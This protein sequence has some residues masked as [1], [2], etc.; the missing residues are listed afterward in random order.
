[1]ADLETDRPDEGEGYV[2]SYLRGLIA[3]ALMLAAAVAV[4]PAAQAHSKCAS[5]PGGGHA[6]MRD[7]TDAGTG[8]HE[9]VDI[10]DSQA[11]GNYV[12]VRAQTIWLGALLAYTSRAAT[13][14]GTDGYD[15]NGSAAG[16]STYDYS[17]M[18]SYRP[19]LFNGIEPYGLSVCI[20][21]EGC[22]VMTNDDGTFDGPD[23]V[24]QPD[25]LPR[26]G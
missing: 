3:L 17:R 15:V 8:G 6:C 7:G 14:T 5:H 9:F 21:N 25:S 22:G 11:D 4:T 10:C 1:M 16:C 19:T 20:Q 24:W 2:K 13:H 18:K 12:Y 23:G 26:V